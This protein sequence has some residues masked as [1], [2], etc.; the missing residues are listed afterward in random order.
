MK[1]GYKLFMVVGDCSDG[2]SGDGS[3][4]LQQRD[5]GSMMCNLCPSLPFPSLPASSLFY[6]LNIVYSTSF[7]YY[8]SLPRLIPGNKNIGNGVELSPVSNKPFCC[9]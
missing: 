5:H 3:V 9:Q 8:L 6:S 2:G 7:D 4:C 1:D